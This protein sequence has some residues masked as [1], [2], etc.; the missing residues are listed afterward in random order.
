MSGVLQ[1]RLT[2]IFIFS[3]FFF[4]FNQCLKSSLQH[5]K[6]VNMLG[7]KAEIQYYCG[8][9]NHKYERSLSK[10]KRKTQKLELHKLNSVIN[11]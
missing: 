1:L 2:E 9:R 3:F 11:G 8:H 6:E 5:V 7:N 10:D 4:V